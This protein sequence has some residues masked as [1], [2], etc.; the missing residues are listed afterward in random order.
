MITPADEQ[1][2]THSDHRVG[3]VQTSTNDGGLFDWLADYQPPRSLPLDREALRIYEHAYALGLKVEKPGTPLVTFSTVIAA[4]LTGQDETSR[5]FADLATKYGPLEV[6]VFEDKGTDRA[7]VESVRPEAGKPADI[8]LSEDKQLLTVSARSLLGIAE[9]W[10]QRVGGSDVGVRHLVASYVLNPPAAH[11]SQMQKWQFQ[12]SQWREV[13]FKWV[14]ERYT[15]E[16]WIA[17][18]HRP[19][20]AQAIPEIEPTEVKGEALAFPGDANALGVLQQAAELHS[21]R[22]DPWLR[23]QTLWHALIAR[24]KETGSVKPLAPLAAAVEKGSVQY[25]QAF[26]GYFLSATGGPAIAFDALDISPRVLNALETARELAVATRKEPM[27]VVRVSVLH[28]AG[29]LVSRRV[30]CDP[31]LVSFGFQPNDLRAKLIE[32]ATAQGESGDAWRD[33]LGVEEVAQAGRALDLNSDEPEAVVRVDETWAEDPLRIRRDV[34]TFGALLASKSL[35]PPLSIGL[36]GPWGS[37]KTTFLKRLRRAVEGRTMEARAA[38][39][40]GKPTAYVL[41]VVHVD[42]N[43]WHFAEGALTSSL[44]DTIL[45]KLG[46]YITDGKSTV[47]KERERRILEKL[48]STK[49]KVEAAEAVVAAASAVFMRAQTNLTEKQTEAANAAVSLQSAVSSVWAATRNTFADSSDVKKSGVLNTLGE[50]IMGA[51]EL[52]TRFEA[53]RKRPARMLGELGWAGTLFFALLAIGLPLAVAWLSGSILKTHE[54]G[55]VLSIVTAALSVISLWLKAA[56]D[57]V[58]KVDKALEEVAQGYDKG[59]AEDPGVNQAHAKLATAK[60]SAAAAVSS[61]H[62]AQEDW[63]RAIADVESAKLPAQLLQLVTSRIDAQS[64]N[65]ELTTTSLARADL[66]AISLLLRAQRGESEKSGVIGGTTPIRTVDRVVLYIDDLDRCKPQDVVRVLQLVHMLLAF[67]L[68]VVVVAVDARWVEESLRQSYPWLAVGGASGDAET[69][70]AAAA[71]GG[72][73]AK[74]S[75]SVPSR[76]TP[77]D[78]LEKIFQISFWLRPMAAQQAAEY[79]KSLVRVQVPRSDLPV[80]G[81]PVAW[82][83]SVFAKIE[84]DSTELDYMRYLAA[85]VGS[86]PRRVKRLVNTYRLIKA[87]LSDPQLETFVTR[88]AV[89]AGRR[90]LSGPYQLVIGLLVIGTGAPALAGRIFREFAEC[91]PSATPD[92]IVKRFRSHNHPDWNMAAQ[93]IEVLM[94]TQKAKD[95]SELRNWA[96][97]V[98]RFLLNSPHDGRLDGVPRVET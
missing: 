59:I 41:N 24:R 97:K 14:A 78:Y 42:F 7:T 17:A 56:S 67:E 40:V 52:R 19:A 26:D 75:G 93:V 11:R 57:A 39:E 71:G 33:A 36:F 44:V 47:G 48:E 2:G 79:L 50:T 73:G 90:P 76:T 87:G 84:I 10:A 91:D 4:L 35:E 55:Q 31:E 77:Q 92:D 61:L 53:L 9:S 38:I 32:H 85:Y 70:G 34:E 98:G 83:A 60:A 29:A 63:A 6:A 96:S 86:S 20:P 16:Q 30:D 5:W 13:F 81:T 25:K 66:E 51:K 82:E 37:G 27:S 28:L 8:K 80:V 46:D 64:Y 54:V 15:A 89:D 95:V 22:Q 12:E 68:F 72:D 65:R 94:R 62:V 74:A 58:A 18:S 45:R 69:P 3:S 43:A 88:F 23:V 1:S 49:Q 21:R